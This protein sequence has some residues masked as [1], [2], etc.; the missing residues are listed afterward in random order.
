MKENPKFIGRKYQEEEKEHF[1][2]SLQSFSK[3]SSVPVEGELEKTLEEI[4][5]IETINSL[6]DSE[7]KSIGIKEYSTLSAE[8]I[9]LLS[10]SVFLKKFPD[11][12]AKGFFSSTLDSVYLNKESTDTKARFLSTLLH[13]AIHRASSVKFYGDLENS[14]YDARVGYRINSQW[15]DSGRQKRFRG[16][17]E[18]MV[19][20]TTYKILSKNIEIL[21]SSFGITR[22]DINGPI[23]SYMDYEPILSSIVKKISEDK[24]TDPLEVFNN[25]EKGQFENNIFVLKEI[26]NSFGEGSLSILSL[27]SELKNKQENLLLDKM[28]FDYFGEED[29]EK[30]KIIRSSIISFFNEKIK[31]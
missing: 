6:L 28:I 4:K 24:K 14:I 20:Y 3:E 9:H 25:L 18:L 27:L 22:E 29:A 17:N 15:K 16:F 5:I 12:N 31:S 11:T 10:N 21:E 2:S 26:E 19:D 1:A 8:K 7:L 23:Y 13:E 30:R